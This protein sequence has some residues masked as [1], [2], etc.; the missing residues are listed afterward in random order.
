MPEP[1]SD[2]D[3]RRD[4][5][6]HSLLPAAVSEAVLRAPW[7]EGDPGGEPRGDPYPPRVR[8]AELRTPLFSESW[9]RLGELFLAG[10]FSSGLMV[11]KRLVDGRIARDLRAFGR[12]PAGAGR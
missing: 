10:V 6:D 1:G 12:Y 7:S 2:I 9:A 4:P 5:A 3:D 8:F 11:L